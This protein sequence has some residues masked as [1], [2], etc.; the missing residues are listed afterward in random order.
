MKKLWKFYRDI[1]SQESIDHTISGGIKAQITL[2]VVTILTVL[3]VAALVVTCLNIGLGR[4][5]TWS[6][7][8]WVIYNNFVDSGNQF[9]QYGWTNRLAVIVISLLGSVLLSGVLISTISNI[10]ERRVDAIRTG[11]TYY[12]HINNHYAIIGYSDI[13]SSLIKELH[14]EDTKATILVMSSQESELVRHSLQSQLSKSEEAQV[15]I[16]FGNIES[17][18]ELHRLNINRAKE[19]YIL[20][21]QGDYG[22]DSKN[23]QCVHLVSMLRGKSHDNEIMP[24]YTQLDQQASY[25]VIQKLDLPKNYYCYEEHTD[26]KAFYVPNIYFRPFNLHENWARR[27]WSL[28]TLDGDT[29]Y[30]P[31]DY[32]PIR[33]IP[34]SQSHYKASSDKQVHL[35]I[36]GFG[37][38]G[39]ALLLEALRICHYANYDDTQPSSQRTRTRITIID[40]DMITLRQHFIA[41]YPNLDQQVDDIC[42]SYH[43]GDLRSEAIRSELEQWSYDPRQMLTIAVCIS[44]PDQSIQLGLNLPAPVYQS[45]TRVLIRQEIQTDLGQVIH[46]D[47]KRYR[48]VKVFGMMEQSISKHILQDELASYV[49]QEYN[50]NTYIQTLHAYTSSHAPQCIETQ[51]RARKEWFRLDENMRWANR[52]QIDAYL[53]YLRTLGYEVTRSHAEIEQSVSPKEFNAQF[54]KEALYILMRMEKYRWNAERT[55]EG[56]Q[57]GPVRNNEHRTHP[58]II[59]FHE[60]SEKEKQKDKNII[61]N[62]PYLLE[63]GGYK[64][65]RT[66]R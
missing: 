2:L 4:E 20:G 61:I 9:E 1:F 58:L 59:S 64:L 5:E 33:L 53:V 25:S 17:I 21:E 23:I 50:E 16:Y 15:R 57:Y 29:P 7:Q 66:T 3:L 18:E 13:T 34:D 37:R 38:M 42:I 55:I 65:I 52:Y 49:N 35:V 8:L 10:I 6:E 12:K 32:E 30:D 39:Q 63:L 51:Q 19:V 60:L 24:V 31:L 46:N 44:D 62:L 45:D 41:L 40:L 11:K 28:Y 36:A 43:N 47:T 27:L 56:W 22:R 14:R 26:G 54:P 48:H